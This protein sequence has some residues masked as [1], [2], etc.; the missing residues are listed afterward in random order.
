MAYTQN[1]CD[2][3]RRSLL[4]AEAMNAYFFFFLDESW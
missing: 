4:I 1:E 3:L 2:P